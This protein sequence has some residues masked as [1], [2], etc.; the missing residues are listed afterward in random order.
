MLIL[1]RSINEQD[2]KYDLLDQFFNLGSNDKV[3]PRIFEM[4]IEETE[5]FCRT[6]GYDEQITNLGTLAQIM[7]I[8]GR[9]GGADLILKFATPVCHRLLFGGLEDYYDVRLAATFMPYLKFFEDAQ[10]LAVMALDK[11]EEYSNDSSY[12]RIKWVISINMISNLVLGVYSEVFAQPSNS[13]PGYDPD[14][15]FSQHFSIAMDLCEKY[16]Y[17]SWKAVCLIRKGCYFK[18]S[19]LVLDNLAWL[20]KYDVNMFEFMLEELGAC[21][22]DPERLEEEA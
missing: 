22:I 13:L 14:L 18:N 19:K 3:E 5:S 15:I 6:Y 7:L 20:K 4:F 8:D 11:L 1:T 2:R 17:L 10:D 21:G 12:E 16:E 9:D